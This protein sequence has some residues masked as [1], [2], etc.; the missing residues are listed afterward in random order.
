MSFEIENQRR[1]R[2]RAKRKAIYVQNEN[3]LSN[4][5]NR[6]NERKEKKLAST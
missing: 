3:E 6:L 5:E 2:K 4:R 1:E